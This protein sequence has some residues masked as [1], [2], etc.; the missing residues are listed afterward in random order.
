LQYGQL[1]ASTTDT[2]AASRP[3]QLAASRIL[4]HLWN[5][6]YRSGSRTY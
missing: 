5:V 1:S 2:G 6:A 3:R 4:N